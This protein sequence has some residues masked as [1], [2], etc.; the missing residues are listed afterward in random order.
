MRCGRNSGVR[1]WALVLLSLLLA[2][3]ST[4]A[5]ID[6]PELAEQT[7]PSVVHLSVLDAGEREVASGTG[8]FVDEGRIATNE[9]VVSRAHAV[10]AKL[11]DGRELRVDGLLAADRDKDV[12]LLQ[13]TGSDL[14][15][16]LALGDSTSLRQ[17]EEVVV[18]GSPRGL[19]GSLSTGVVSALRGEGLDGGIEAERSARSWAI[20]ITAAISP[21]SSGSP[22][23]NREGE[24]VAVAVGIIG[25]GTGLGFGVPIEEVKDM[26]AGLGENPVPKP[27]S[28][29]SSTVVRNL[30]ISGAFFGAIIATFFVAG[31]IKRR[32]ARR[33][34]KR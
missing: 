4:A 6:L 19:A 20:Q 33:R 15:K 32:L 26:L 21:G 13:V 1:R 5:A 27:F 24:V 12:A 28:G 22:I 25:Q 31:P 34:K 14:P 11:S 17:G 2:F 7:K 16:P 10:I 30:I 23:M 9:H 18:I 29:G 8:F 3:A